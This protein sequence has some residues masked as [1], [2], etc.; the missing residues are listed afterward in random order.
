MV[1]LEILGASDELAYV[2]EEAFLLRSLAPSPQ[3][4]EIL[5]D[6]A[7]VLWGAPLQ[8]RALPG[9][10]YTDGRSFLAHGI[11][12]VTLMAATDGP[13]P[14]STLQAT[15]G[16]DCLFRPVSEPSTSLKRS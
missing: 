6:R 15:A 7:R 12:A 1:N 2:S 16:S 14:G 13:L 5:N 11:P 4:V 3:V 8:A 9:V 10:M